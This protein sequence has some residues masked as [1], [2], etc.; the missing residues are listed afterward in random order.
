MKTCPNCGALVDDSAKFCPKCGER[1]MR[2]SEHV[3]ED[4]APAEAV[5]EAAAPEEASPVESVP[6]PAVEDVAPAEAAPAAAPE[7]A[8][9]VQAAEDVAPAEAA[10]APAAEE[11]SP[12][13]AA[14]P[15]GRASSTCPSCGHVNPAGAPY[16]EVCGAPLSETTWDARYGQPRYHSQADQPQPQVRSSGTHFKGS[17]ELQDASTQ[18]QPGQ[19]QARPVPSGS[20]P[21]PASA[22]DQPVNTD[23]G[24]R[25]AKHGEAVASL[26]LGIIGVVIYWIVAILFDALFIGAGIGVVLGIVGLVLASM[27][28]KAGNREGIRTAGFV[29]SLISIILNVIYAVACGSFVAI[30]IAAAESAA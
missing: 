16:C 10:P 6:A 17:A 28:K 2:E 1:L 7:E 11:A 19:Q 5:P 12:V 27:A 18:P 8:S 22:Y 9:P 15:R 24:N 26:V 20:E 4:V 25:T 3:A 30:T 21:H 23:G 13:Q 29:L 14:P